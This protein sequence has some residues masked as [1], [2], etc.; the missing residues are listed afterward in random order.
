VSNHDAAYCVG[1]VIV[2]FVVEALSITPYILD[3]LITFIKTLI[4]D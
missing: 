3:L 4:E 2:A 1:M